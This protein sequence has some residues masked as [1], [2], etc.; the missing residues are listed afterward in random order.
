MDPQ[1]IGRKKSIP[2]PHGARSRPNQGASVEENTRS[3][4]E[5]LAFVGPTQSRDHGRVGLLAVAE[6]HAGE[7]PK[8]QDPPEWDVVK[9]V[10][11]G[12]DV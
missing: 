1:T 6:S 8:R 4:F 11:I 7:L 10:W 5:I 3:L 2:P 9:S 12:K